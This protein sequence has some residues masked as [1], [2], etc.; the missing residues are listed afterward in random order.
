MVQ[1]GF[2]VA[3]VGCGAV[4]RRA[5]RQLASSV[6]F[7]RIVLVDRHRDRA[8]QI[9]AS[10]ALGEAVE[11]RSELQGS[12]SLASLRDVDVLVLATAAPH[13][14]LSETALAR[15]LHVVS[16]SDDPGE[17][18]ALL[19][20]DHAA[21]AAGRNLVIGASFA[22]GLSCA[23]TRHAAAGFESVE[24]IHVASFGTGGPACARLHHRS[25]KGETVDWWDGTWRHRAAGSGRELCWFPDP[26]GGSDCYRAAR[27]DPLL[28][29]PAFPGATRIVARIA[30][31]RRDRLTAWLPMLRR[32]HP[33]GLLGAIRVE[34]RGR[35]NG[36]FDAEIL[37]ALDRPALAAGTVAAVSALW[38][39]QGHFRAGA[40]GLA[41][42][43][44][45]PVDF[46]Q[47]LATRGVRAARFEGSEAAV[48]G[49][50]APTATSTSAAGST[51]AGAAGPTLEI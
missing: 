19:Q 9:A 50:P 17:V 14:D 37:G 34:V 23:L 5:A 35:R 44:E 26:V 41:Q 22:P 13:R 11:V 51:F 21:R 46:L 33:E 47:E 45:R 20:L 15:G 3:L 39:S 4:G 27:P 43:L 40:G 10:L 36:S 7:E 16:C 49:T 2:R 6:G 48:A 25:L 30:A 29:V 8:E 28:L 12:G 18:R 31:S 32:P 24:E 1:S 42:L 38:A